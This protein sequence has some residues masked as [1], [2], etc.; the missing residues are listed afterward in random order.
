LTPVVFTATRSASKPSGSIFLLFA[1]LIFFFYT[2]PI[3]VAGNI[4]HYLTTWEEA[5]KVYEILDRESDKNIVVIAESV[6]HYSIYQYESIPFWY[7][8]MHKERVLGDLA[9]HTIRGIFVV[10]RI[11][12]PSL[13]PASNNELYADYALETVSERASGGSTFIRVSKVKP[14]MLE[15]NSPYTIAPS[16]RE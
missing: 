13:Q 15:P 2:Q 4:R 8:N 11:N 5:Q 9:R 16:H 10:Q 6:V 1:A 12:L 7:A 3:A 14:I